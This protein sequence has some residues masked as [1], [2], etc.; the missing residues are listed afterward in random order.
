ML[1]AVA[2]TA[3]CQT[4]K[5]PRPASKRYKKPCVKGFAAE[6]L[7]FTFPNLNFQAAQL[8][9]EIQILFRLDEGNAVAC[10]ST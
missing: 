2:K 10:A 3:P 1:P 5:S 9:H 6:Y 8:P 7:S 4:K